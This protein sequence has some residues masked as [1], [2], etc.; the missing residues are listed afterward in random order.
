MATRQLFRRPPAGRRSVRRWFVL[1][2]MALVLL[3]IGMGL[4]SVLVDLPDSDLLALASGVRIFRFYGV[5]VQ[6]VLAGLV[7]LCWCQ[8]VDA[9][10][11]RGIVAR[12]EYEKVLGLRWTVAAFLAAYLLLVPIGPVTL[13]NFLAH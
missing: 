7:V 12:H 9:G 10:Q 1:V 13:Y 5:L 4:M 8:I 2:A 11:R 3:V 6:V